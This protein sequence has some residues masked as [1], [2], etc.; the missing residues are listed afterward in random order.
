MKPTGAYREGKKKNLK[1]FPPVVLVGE[2]KSS[3]IIFI[4]TTDQNLICRGRG[5]QSTSKDTSGKP[6]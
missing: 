4:S 2:E 3:H 6:L 5:Q 1:N